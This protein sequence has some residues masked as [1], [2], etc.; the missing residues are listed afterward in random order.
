MAGR[1]N[2]RV[3]FEKLQRERA[4]Q[5]RQ[6]EKRARRQGKGTETTHEATDA[7]PT[8]GPRE[9]TQEEIDLETIMRLAAQ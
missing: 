4:R 2:G 5:E 8:D 1:S 6:A 9:K 7:P 3:T